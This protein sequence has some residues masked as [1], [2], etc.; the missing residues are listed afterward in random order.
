MW[1]A[2]RRT[3]APS[4]G[5]NRRTGGVRNPCP[6]C[7]AEAVIAFHLRSE[8]RKVDAYLNSQ[9]FQRVG[10]EQLTPTKRRL[11]AGDASVT[12][13]LFA[14]G[15][16]RQAQAAVRAERVGE[17]VGAGQVEEPVAVEKHDG[18]GVQT[19]EPS[20]GKR[21]TPPCCSPRFCPARRFRGPIIH[22]GSF[23][24]ETVK[25]DGLIDPSFRGRRVA[26]CLRPFDELCV[27]PLAESKS[28]SVTTEVIA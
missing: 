2:R 28:G 21:R 27:F 17:R 6:P 16:S 14:V 25:A 24:A 9:G 23:G 19:G 26:D 10:F 13:T 12:Y 11:L 1:L 8:S 7:F 4:R 3:E 22:D 15:C 5:S 18:D 20:D